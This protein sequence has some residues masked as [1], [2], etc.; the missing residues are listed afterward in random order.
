M[1]YFSA[2]VDMNMYVYL[3]NCHQCG[4]FGSL[5]R[6]VLL[7]C[8]LVVLLAVHLVDPLVVLLVGQLVVHLVTH[9]KHLH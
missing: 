9:T 3:E 7:E 5:Q 1:N 2:R 8:H 4:T 6:V